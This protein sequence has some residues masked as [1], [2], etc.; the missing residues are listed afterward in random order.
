M[1]SYI[2][3]FFSF[4]GLLPVQ[5]TSIKLKC[6]CAHERITCDVSFCLSAEDYLEDQ[7]DFL[8]VPRHQELLGDRAKEC[9]ISVIIEKTGLEDRGQY[10]LSYVLFRCVSMFLR[11]CLIFTL[12]TEMYLI[13]H[14]CLA[15]VSLRTSFSAA[16]WRRLSSTPYS[17][18]RCSPVSTT[19]GYRH[20]Q[21]ERVSV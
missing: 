11:T 10:T 18:I 14:F 15:G 12:S 16:A 3:F 19:Q 2:L 7:T 8:I 1:Y 17:S 13:C 21:R 6:D 4:L 5:V 20:T 9:D